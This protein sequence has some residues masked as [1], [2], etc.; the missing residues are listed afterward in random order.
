MMQF[1]DVCPLPPPHN[2]SQ[3]IIW[4]EK[5]DLHITPLPSTHDFT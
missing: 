4:M 2:T 1:Q 3:V 5:M